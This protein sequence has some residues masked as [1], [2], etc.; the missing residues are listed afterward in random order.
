MN[1]SDLANKLN[2]STDNTQ[3]LYE[4]KKDL[5]NLNEEIKN[6]SVYSSTRASNMLKRN[7]TSFDN[8]YE[9]NNAMNSPAMDFGC[10]N[11]HNSGNYIYWTKI[12]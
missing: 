3:R 5:L 6:I 4:K 7:A 11:N 2:Q 1:F 10:L 8:T 9:S 12:F